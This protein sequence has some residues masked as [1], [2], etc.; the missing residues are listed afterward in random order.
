MNCNNNLNN[1]TFINMK[2][3]LLSIVL[4]IF[5]PF[6]LASETPPPHL[7]LLP[8]AD[9][10]QKKLSHGWLI[11]FVKETKIDFHLAQRELCPE[12]IA[13]AVSTFVH[14]YDIKP[15]KRSRLYTQA[16]YAILQDHPDA[17]NH[18]KNVG[19]LS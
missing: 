17:I 13:I 3:I 5:T 15:E 4:L 19:Y 8:S 10:L 12:A 14:N 11:E 2:K 9:A 6:C 1:E 16:I 18:L 7:I